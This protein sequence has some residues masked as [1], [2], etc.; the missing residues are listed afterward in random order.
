MK[1]DVCTHCKWDSGGRVLTHVEGCPHGGPLS[2]PIDME[3]LRKDPREL[4][5]ALWTTAGLFLEHPEHEGCRSQLFC[6]IGAAAMTLM[7]SSSSGG[8]R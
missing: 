5:Q 6:L 8:P 7:G 1:C 3:A 2:C 4:G